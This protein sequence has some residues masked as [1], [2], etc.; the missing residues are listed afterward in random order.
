MLVTHYVNNET[1][2]VDSAYDC[3]HDDATAPVD[4]T[5]KGYTP[6]V[7]HNRNENCQYCK[8]IEP[9]TTLIKAPQMFD[10][11]GQPIV[12]LTGSTVPNYYTGTGQTDVIGF[13][14]PQVEAA[15]ME[16]FFRMNIMKYLTRYDKKGTP[17]DDLNKA[18]NYLG[19]LIEHV[20]QNSPQ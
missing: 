19:K 20:K 6:I 12:T 5:E 16:G 9:G 14:T 10:S 13:M 18:C 3:V 15:Q 7:T 2:K 17:I 8:V 11:K 1:G 4:L